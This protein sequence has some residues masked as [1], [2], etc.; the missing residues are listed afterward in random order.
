MAAIAEDLTH[1]GAP[2]PDTRIARWDLTPTAKLGALGAEPT[3]TDEEQAIV[4]VLHRFAENEMRP[5][6]QQLDRMS[7]EAVIAPDSPL[8]P[9]IE[10]YHDLGFST[11]LLMAMEPQA[12]AKLQCLS[13]EELAWGDVG[14]AF[15]LGA[16]TF[17]RFMARLF[18]NDYLADMCPETMI[19]CWGI[20]EPDHGSDNLDPSRQAEHAGGIHSRPNCVATLKSD[21]IIVNGQKSAWASNGTIAEMCVLYCAADSGAGPDAEHGCVVYVPCDAQGVTKGKP[22]DKMGQRALN[23]GEVFFDQVELP[24]E[25]LLAGPENYQRA[26]YAIHQEANG[27]V[28]AALVGL[29]RAAYE[30][31]HAYA[32]ERKQGGVPIIRHQSVV[33]RLFHMYRKLESSRALARRVV[34]YNATA[35]QPSL[36]SAMAAKVGCTQWAFEI[37]SDALQMFGGNGM[38]REYPMEKLFRDARAGLIEDGCNEM[39]AIKGGYSLTDPDLL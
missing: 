34:E 12:R 36:Q 33:T 4:D 17:P 25:N 16:A 19:G 7:P 10:K 37:A 6:G 5:L 2:A 29:A 11:D 14:L 22:L 32:H 3:L 1:Q 13:Y 9:F 27:L 26:V 30:L 38:T 35:E 20:T 15:T 18:G 23:Q 24:M 31:A 28:A 39:L 8:W 21:K